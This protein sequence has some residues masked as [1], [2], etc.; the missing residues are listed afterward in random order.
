MKELLITV[1]IKQ[2]RYDEMLEAAKQI[3][4]NYA[5]TGIGMLDTPEKVIEFASESLWTA[6]STTDASVCSAAKEIRKQ[7]L[8]RRRYPTRSRR[9]YLRRRSRTSSRPLSRQ[10]QLSKLRSLRSTGSSMRSTFARLTSTALYGICSG[11]WSDDR[12]TG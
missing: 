4:Q 3:A 9:S 5:E 11:R 7:R 1:H 8:Q 10:S 12:R 2:E 6:V